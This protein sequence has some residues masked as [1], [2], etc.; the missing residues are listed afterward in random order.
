MATIPNPPSL[1][2]RNQLKFLIFDAPS[3]SNIQLYVEQC[4]KHNVS[5]VVRVCESTYDTS[6]MVKA[7]I[8]VHDLEY[9]DGTNPPQDVLVQWRNIVKEARKN[10]KTVAVHCIAG[11]GRAPVVVCTSLID[12]G[13]DPMSAVD[14]VRK[15]RRGAVNA[16]QLKYL[17]NYKKA[18]GGKEDGCVIQ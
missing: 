14:F 4:K 3:D 10:G 7:G 18:S 17:R 6:P 16:Q 1:V 5:D 2:T 11:L 13:M 15:Q 12:S 8:K 9:S